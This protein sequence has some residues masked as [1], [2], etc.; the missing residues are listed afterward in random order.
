M[1]VHGFA[2]HS[3]TEDANL[4]TL[5]F[6]TLD[7]KRNQMIMAV[8]CHS[9]MKMTA[10]VLPQMAARKHGLVLNI[11]NFFLYRS[12]GLTLNP[13]CI[14]SMLG[15]LPSA[16][17]SVYSASKAFLRNWSISVAAEVSAKGV[18]VEHINTLFV[19]TA[20]SKIRK[21]S[22][23]TPTPN[24]FVR[25]VLANCGITHDTT[26]YTP[27]AVLDFIVGYVFLETDLN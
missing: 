20:M 11:G 10:I 22:L 17:L 6:C 26:P 9:V 23:T 21:P 2:F 24:A 1:K 7:A 5:M 27:H 14:G 16:L 13:C 25:S 19:Q 4:R 15:K 8:N 12:T 3:W 18:H